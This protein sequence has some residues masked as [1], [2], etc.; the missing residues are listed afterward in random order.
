MLP[1]VTRSPFHVLCLLM[2]VAI[3]GGCA[4]APGRTT[5][6]DPWEGMNRRI[7]KFNDAV[8]RATLKPVA[9]GY[10]KITPQWMRTGI[11]NFFENLEM[12]WVMVNELL[13]GKPGLMAQ[14]TCRF[15]I[16]STVGLGGF[17]DVASKFDLAAENEDF[18][19]T[20]AV[21]GI[22][23]GPYLMLPIFGP[24]TVRDGIGRG[25]DYYGRPLHYADIPWET[26]TGLSA[27]DATQSR[28]ALLS[29]EE[30]LG[31]A[32]DR[33]GIIRDAWLQRREYLVYDGAPPEPEPEADP[34][35]D[36]ADAETPA[37]PENPA[38]TP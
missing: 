11:R 13:Q 22:S 9:K 15:V 5:S 23:S 27:L 6:E 33:Y 2:T 28:D 17:I 10:R 21:W 4:T 38:P 34:A 26:E 14:Q 32:Y 1:P 16:N 36:E 3:L 35:L 12:P 31:Q 18:G 24:A 29:T 37:S 19:Q 25:P 20:L 7:Y 8:D 30:A